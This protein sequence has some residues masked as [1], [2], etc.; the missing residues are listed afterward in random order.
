VRKLPCLFVATGECD[1]D[2]VAHH[3]GPKKND[4]TGVPLCVRHHGHW[5]DANGVFKG[6]KKESRRQW[7]GAAIAD[8]RQDVAGT[9]TQGESRPCE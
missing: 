3:A 1:G 9:Q 6:W 7:A 4:S 5:H 8:T 2:V